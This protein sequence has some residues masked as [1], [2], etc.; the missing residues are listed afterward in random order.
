MTPFNVLKKAKRRQFSNR[1]KLK[2]A[3]QQAASDKQKEHNSKQA[4]SLGTVL[5]SISFMSQFYYICIP[6]QAEGRLFIRLSQ[7]VLEETQKPSF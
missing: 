3:M 5:A 1:T 7:N 2:A 4:Q 6:G